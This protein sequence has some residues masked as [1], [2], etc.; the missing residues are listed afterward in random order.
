MTNK[1]LAY[2]RGINP[3]QLLEFGRNLILALL[4]SA[5]AFALSTSAGRL[6]VSVQAEQPVTV[7]EPSSVTEPVADVGLTAPEPPTVATGKIAALAGFLAKK[8]R[9]SPNATRNMV[10]TAY[11]EG[12]RLGVDPLLIIAV[13]AVESSFN[14]I[15]ESV[16]GAKGLMQVIP[17]YHVDKLG[18]DQDSAVLDP[19][20]N[21]QV[22]ALILKEYIQRGG[23]LAA[24]L[25]LYNGS[26]ADPN[27]AYANKVMGEQQRLQQVVRRVRADV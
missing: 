17:R 24:G 6:E 21:I 27:N 26:P 2:P 12:Q 14:P 16:A 8:Y 5:A 7:A 25:Q 4:A 1:S 13:M 9:V 15:A 3:E 20:T 18:S 22:G 10:R 23:S 19:Q 11:T